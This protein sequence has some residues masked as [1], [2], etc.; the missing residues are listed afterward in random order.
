MPARSP[1]RAPSGMLAPEKLACVWRRW[2]CSIRSRRRSLIRAVAVLREPDLFVG[3][4]GATIRSRY[5]ATRVKSKAVVVVE[6]TGQAALR[7]R[8]RSLADWKTHLMCRR[9]VEGALDLPAPLSAKSCCQIEQVV[10]RLAECWLRL[11]SAH[12]AG[13]IR[14]DLRLDAGIPALSNGR[15]FDGSTLPE[16]IS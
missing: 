4:P 13:P 10:D 9:R 12:R 15:Y 8:W 5:W 7:C 14:S 3:R 6:T 11:D 16:P 1:G 2:T